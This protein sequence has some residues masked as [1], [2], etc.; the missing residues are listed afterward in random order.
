MSDIRTVLFRPLEPGRPPGFDWQTSPPQLAADDGLETAVIISLFTDRRAADDDTLP[1]GS[2][3]RRGWWADTYP[4][5]P[6]DRIGSRLWLLSREKDLRAVVHRAREYA[7]EALGWMVDDGIAARVE[8]RAGWVDRVS[9]AITE[10][11]S[12][13]S[14]PGVLGLGVVVHRPDAPVARFR[15]DVFWGRQ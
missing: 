12:P 6:G 10:A 8:V 11:K 5:I 15:F 1:D 7:E 2:G 14:R 9:G 3:D 13:Q 4:D